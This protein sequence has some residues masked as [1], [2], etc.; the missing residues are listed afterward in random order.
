[1]TEHVDVETS[2]SAALM[3]GRRRVR[4]SRIA[5]VHSTASAPV[6]ACKVRR[7]A[8]PTVRWANLN[9]C[10]YTGYRRT[11]AM[12]YRGREPMPDNTTDDEPMPDDAHCRTDAT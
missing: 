5:Q 4:T 2:R 8:W 10:Q 7:P 1:M 11:D 3:G 9:R 12:R 6:G